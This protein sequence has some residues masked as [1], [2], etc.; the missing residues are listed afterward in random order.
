MHAF[1]ERESALLEAIVR[2]VRY[3]LTEDMPLDAPMPAR[4]FDEH[5]GATITP[6]GIGGERALQ[7]FDEWLAAGCISTDHPRYLSFIP[8]APSAAA[9]MFDLVVSASSIYGGSWLEGAG[10]VWAENQA[11]AWLAR[12][13]GYPDSAEGVFVPGGT[14]GNLSALVTAR[15]RAR[16]LADPNDARRWVLVTGPGSHS[17]IEHVANVM[18]VDVIRCPAEPGTDRLRADDVRAALAAL[19]PEQRCFAIV[20]TCGHTNT[21]VMDDLG[22]IAE[23]AAEQGIWMHVDGAY[24]AALLASDTYRALCAGIARSDS[25]IVDPHKWL[26]TPFDC[27]ALLYR[28]ATW[29]RAAHRQHAGYLDALH[30]STDPSDLAV[31]LS[32]RARGLPFWFSLATNGT[33]AYSDAIDTSMETARQARERIATD[34]RFELVIGD[35]SIVVFRRVGWGSDDYRRWSDEL[36]RSG[37]GFVVPTN[38][39]GEIMLRL[40]FV[41]PQVTMGDIEAILAT[42]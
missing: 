41:N 15:H 33:Q 16:S 25:F 34:T 26:F 28:E 7:L 18:D 23:V 10:A 24:G 14:L 17:S 19:L 30:G 2:Y 37:T 38:F 31:H 27:C 39:Q 1:T 5:V 13:A 9:S 29:A 11:L 6:D 36:L 21:G 35:L 20:A 40:A 8:N 32:R 22:P 3:R 12:R 42:L 4:E